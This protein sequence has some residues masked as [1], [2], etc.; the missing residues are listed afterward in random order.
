LDFSKN[1]ESPYVNPY[2]C[3]FEFYDDRYKGNDNPETEIDLCIPIAKRQAGLC[4]ILC[5]F[6]R[7]SWKIAA[8]RRVRQITAFSWKRVTRQ[9]SVRLGFQGNP[10]IKM[11]SDFPVEDA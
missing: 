5:A 3:D 9:L 10:A 6:P 4:G 7:G 2:A 1:P 11:P 8:A